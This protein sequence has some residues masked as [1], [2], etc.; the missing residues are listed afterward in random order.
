MFT[1]YSLFVAQI[2]CFHHGLPIRHVIFWGNHNLPISFMVVASTSEPENSCHSFSLRNDS[3]F[4]SPNAS[5][6]SVNSSRVRQFLPLGVLDVLQSD[7]GHDT[8]FDP[9]AS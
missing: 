7:N 9:E 2:H 8:S 1:E 4:H 3:M 6:S 5:S